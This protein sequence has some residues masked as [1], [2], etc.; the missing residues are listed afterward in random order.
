MNAVRLVVRLVF[1]VILLVAANIVREVP[2][3]ADSCNAGQHA[4]C[5]DQNWDNCVTMCW[6]LQQSGCHGITP[7]CSDAQCQIGT[8][9]CS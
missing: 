1:L 5:T 9:W 4:A 6:V 2:V 7:I 8:Y 3:A